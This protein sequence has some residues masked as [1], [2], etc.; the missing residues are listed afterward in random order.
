M[1]RKQVIEGIC[2]LLCLTRYEDGWTIPNVEKSMAL[3]ER[4]GIDWNE[5]EPVLN[6]F[7]DV[8]TTQANEAHRKRQWSESVPWWEELEKLEE[9]PQLSRRYTNIADFCRRSD[10]EHKLVYIR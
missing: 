3:C 1:P 9:N 10:M 8:T 2:N 6:V 5:Y 4:L 7:R